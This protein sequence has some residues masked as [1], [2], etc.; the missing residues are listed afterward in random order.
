MCGSGTLAIEAAL[1][2]SKR[3]PGLYRSNYSFMHING[4]DSAYYDEVKKE[5]EDQV[6]DQ[7]LPQI[8]ATIYM[9]EPYG[10]QR[11]MQNGPGFWISSNSPG[12]NFRIR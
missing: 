8:I 10:Q 1:L 9:Q 6:T 12:V 3:Y 11:Q 2:A 4:Y 5:I 7:D